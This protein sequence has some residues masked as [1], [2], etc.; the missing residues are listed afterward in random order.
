MIRIREIVD[1]DLRKRIVALLARQ[2]ECS[3]AAIPDWFEL[4]DADYVDL[5]QQLR[6]DSDSE[7]EQYD[8][9]M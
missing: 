8:P 3:V 1:P 9:R 7:V 5:L 2:R 4:D 6:A